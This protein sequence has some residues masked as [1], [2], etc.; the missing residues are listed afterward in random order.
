MQKHVHYWLGVFS[1]SV[2][3][4]AVAIGAW[5][6]ATEKA[7]NLLAMAVGMI[8]ALTIFLFLIIVLRRPIL[9]KFLGVS[10][11][12]VEKITIESSSLVSSTIKGDAEGAR[13]AG[14]AL[15]GSVVGWWVWS[16]FYRWVIATNIALLVAFGGFAGTVLLFEQNKRLREQTTELIEQRKQ[17]QAQNERFDMQNEL[18]SLNL[19]FDFR[20]RLKNLEMTN[21]Q[22]FEAYMLV[23]YDDNKVVDDANTCK[24]TGSNEPLKPM[25]NKSSIAAVSDLTRSDILGERVL[26]ALRYLLEDSDDTVRLGALMALDRI[27]AVAPSGEFTFTGMDI[28][29]LSLN[30]GQSITFSG[31]NVFN[32]DCERCSITIYGSF[33]QNIKASKLASYYSIVGNPSEPV[34]DTE[35]S[36]P[37]AE[38]E[39]SAFSAESTLPQVITLQVV[40]HSILTGTFQAVDDRV[41]ETLR[42]S[43]S[44]VST[45]RTQV[46][47]YPI[48]CQEMERSFGGLRV[49]DY[50]TG[51][52][53]Q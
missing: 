17:L 40:D 47:E 8:L 33:A 32:I 35:L 6:V 30:T 21:K 52:W 28:D 12:S 50:G 39:V 25:P 7:L 31:S 20:Q 46:R 18:A 19:V 22:G 11:A 51:Y 16:N 37:V 1:A 41:T 29:G 38:N 42:F 2:I 24:L 53:R 48:N 14:E 36:A 3:I 5:S 10:E 43:N 34:I 23:A 13:A 45:L 15:A 26:N 27:G 4:V 49:F 9:E 44:Y